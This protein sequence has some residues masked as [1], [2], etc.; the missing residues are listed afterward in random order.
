MFDKGVPQLSSN[1]TS[2]LYSM[3]HTSIALKNISEAWEDALLLMDAKLA[4]YAQVAISLASHTQL[5][6]IVLCRVCLRA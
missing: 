3:Q 1:I 5:T 4:T 2:S 6:A